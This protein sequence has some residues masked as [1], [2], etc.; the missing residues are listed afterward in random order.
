VNLLV[1]SAPDPL[2]VI[3]GELKPGDGDEG[4]LNGVVEFSPVA[5]GGGLMAGLVLSGPGV[6]VG[7]GVGYVPI[8]VPGGFPTMVPGVPE[9]WLVVGPVVVPPAPP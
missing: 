1:K 5:G 4:L 2:L 7:A 3:P 6:A 9:P 8:P